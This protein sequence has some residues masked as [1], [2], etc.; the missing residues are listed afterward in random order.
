M[1]PMCVESDIWELVELFRG[2]GHTKGM[3]LRLL[4]PSKGSQQEVM[5][6]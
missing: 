2:M 4:F 1:E 5:Q 6:L 3:G